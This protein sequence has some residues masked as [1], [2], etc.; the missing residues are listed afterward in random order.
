MDKNDIIY[1]RSVSD[2]SIESHRR[3]TTIIGDGIEKLDDD[4]TGNKGR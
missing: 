4:N 3:N 1:Q 2:A